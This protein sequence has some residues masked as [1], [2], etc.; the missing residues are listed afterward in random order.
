M[1]FD[2]EEVITGVNEI[3]SLETAKDHLRVS[4]SDED[5]MI[6]RMIKTARAYAEQ[7]TQR[8]LIDKTLTVQFY[9]LD[10]ELRFELPF[11]PVDAITSVERIASDGTTTT[12]VDGTNYY[13][14]GLSRKILKL[15]RFY[16]SGAFGGQYQLK[17]V[18]TV[19][20]D[21][22]D[23]E[24]FED[25]ILKAVADMYRNRENTESENP[26]GKMGGEA[27]LN[28]QSLLNPLRYKTWL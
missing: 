1:Q 5:T 15:N 3:V 19:T 11:G 25:A 20:A 2:I 27:M 26:T 14:Q 17:A 23:Q 28:M 18:Y 24:V 12:L 7:Y 21:T 22:R 13:A 4:Y 8:A 16:S 10:G 9:D 6:T